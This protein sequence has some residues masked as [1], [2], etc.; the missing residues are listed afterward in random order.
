MDNC[1][2]MLVHYTRGGSRDDQPSQLKAAMSAPCST[3]N[4]TLFHSHIL[5]TPTHSPSYHA[6]KEEHHSIFRI[7]FYS[8]DY[9]CCCYTLIVHCESSSPHSLFCISIHYQGI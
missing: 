2:R 9:C 6:P 8:E 3:H 4:N 1:C 7:L 5:P